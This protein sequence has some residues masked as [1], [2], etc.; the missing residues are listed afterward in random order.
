VCRPHRPLERAE[1][2]RKQRSVSVYVSHVGRGK[3]REK[4]RGPKKRHSAESREQ[5][6]EG[7]E[8]RAES[9]EL[10]KR[11]RLSS[12]AC[13]IATAHSLLAGNVD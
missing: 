6:A 12:A 11:R 4:E 9:R 5:R 2:L 3:E 13:R 10:P 8:Q 7:K 1:A